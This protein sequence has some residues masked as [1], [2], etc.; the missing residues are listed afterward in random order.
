MVSLFANYKK[1]KSAWDNSLDLGYGILKQNGNN[2]RKTDDKIEFTSKYGRKA[3]KNWYYA[4]LVNFKSQMTAGYD[5]PD[6]STI[7]SNFLAPG[8][9]LGALGMD[10]KPSDELTVFISPLTIKATIVNDEN[11]ANAGAF[12]V[13][14]AEYDNLGNITKKGSNLRSEYGGYLRAQFKKDIMENVNFQTRIDLFSNYSE[15]PTHIDVNWEV[16]IAMKV[17]KYISATVT[18]N[19][20]YDHDIDIAVDE[21]GDNIPDAFGPR[22]Q[23]K[24]VLGVGLSYKF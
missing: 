16:L 19:L 23:F 7:I 17:N 1:G 14:P 18:T 2:V 12:G 20:I 10:Y 15:E 13:D 5:Y 6:D 22:V 8:Y 4:G 3:V 9:V 11:L 21:D 24:E